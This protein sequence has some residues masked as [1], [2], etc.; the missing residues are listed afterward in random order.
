MSHRKRVLL[1]CEQYPPSVG[2]VQEV[3][4]QIAERLAERGYDVVVATGTHPQRPLKA[5]LNGVQVVSF[6][7]TGNRVKGMAGPVANYQQF[8]KD[9]YFDAVLIKAAQQWTFD[10]AIDV[11]HQ[12]T[13]RKVFI[14]CGFSG[15]RDPR[16]SNY[17][18]CMPIWLSYFDELIFYSNTYQ[19]IEFAR[20]N[21]LKNLRLIPNGVDA[22]EFKNASPGQ[23]LDELGIDTAD[24][25]L[26]SVGS[27]IMAKGHWEVLRAFRQARLKRPATLIIN[28]NHALGGGLSRLKRT[29][30]HLL[31]G[32]WPISLE[33][34]FTCLMPG[35]K[36]MI[37][38]LPRNR[39]IQLFSAAKLFVFAS[40][41]EYS[42]LV[43]FEA[44]ASATP[45]IASDAGNSSEIAEWTKAGV[46]VKRSK[47]RVR[48][49]DPADL[50]QSMEFMLE[51]PDLKELGLRARDTV[52][53]QGYTWDR[54]VDD[55]ANALGLN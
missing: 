52:L 47:G 38:N 29:G 22:Q 9:G 27:M 48:A 45:F 5:M 3:M 54:I 10:A 43:L 42:P 50:R 40:H 17:F 36:V 20:T 35:K 24:D 15:L 1:C 51:R 33:A 28:G 8:L 6:G 2:G 18:E 49:C 4:R 25:V 41:V 37:I 21:G 11:M 39:L 55:Y 12:I 30:K 26:L 19:D 16:F 46:I 34:A 13:A 32:L 7:I 31:E 23:I 14:P 53:E 44:A